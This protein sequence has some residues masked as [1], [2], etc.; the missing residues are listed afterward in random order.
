M[1]KILLI[2]DT[3]GLVRN[4]V[5]EAMLEV[6]YVIHVGD[7][8]NIEAYCELKTC[9]KIEIVRGNNDWFAELPEY[10][11]IDIYGVKIFVMHDKEHLPR[12]LSKYDVVVYG[13]SHKHAIEKKGN[14]LYI[15]PGSAGRARFDYGLSMGI[16]EIENGKIEYKHIIIE[17]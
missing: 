11:D 1:K 13:H 3:H 15:N 9:E 6:D 10:L 17:R 16:L 5:H 7:V 14:T 8:D 2:S 12:D 4:E